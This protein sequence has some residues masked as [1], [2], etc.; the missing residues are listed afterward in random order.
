MVTWPERITGERARTGKRQRDHATCTWDGREYRVLT[1]SAT[2]AL[3]RKLVADGCPD[4]PWE[5]CTPDGT[6]SLHSRS[7]HAWAR[8]TV[9]EDD[10]GAR[11]HPFKEHP[12]AGGSGG[13]KTAPRAS[14]GGGGADEAPEALTD[15]CELVE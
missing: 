1:L 9:R 7:L 13:V 6:R 14:A 5:A 12:N 2:A 8:V 15:N 3:A 4:Q 11:L 10:R